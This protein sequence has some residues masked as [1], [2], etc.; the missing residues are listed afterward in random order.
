MNTSR[1][2]E[3][4]LTTR[5]VQQGHIRLAYLFGSLAKGNERPDS[6]IDIAVKADAPLTPQQKIDLIEELATLTGRPVDLVD[7]RQAGEPLTGQILSHGK[8][9]LGSDEEHAALICRHLFDQA[10]FLPYRDR[11][12]AERRSAWIGP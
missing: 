7:L 8:R 11:I 2:L 9:L 5:L 6:D 3:S 12:L 10:D 1:S 4:Q